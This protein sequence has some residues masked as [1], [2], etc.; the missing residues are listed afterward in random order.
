MDAIPI[1]AM[2]SSQKAAVLLLVVATGCQMPTE[3]STTSPAPTTSDTATAEDPAESQVYEMLA[4]GTHPNGTQLRVDRIEMLSDSVVVSGSVTN[5]SSYGIS[6]DRGVTR[7]AADDGEVALLIEGLPEEPI[8]PG[9]ELAVALRFGYLTNPSAV[10]LILNSGEGSSKADPTTSSPNIELG[11]IDL[12]SETSRPA[13]PDPIP[14]RR[15]IA[16]PTGVELQIEG[17]NFT[18]NRIGVWVRIANPGRTNASIA[19]SIA[20]SLLVDD[21]GNRYPLVLPERE[22]SMVIP[23]GSAR[24]GVLSFAGRIHPDAT[25]LNLGLNAGAA[26]DTGDENTIYPRLISEAIDLDGDSAV[27]PL[28]NPLMVPSVAEHPSGLR[29]E[30]VAIAFQSDSSTAELLVPNFTSDQVALAAFP[31]YLKD[32]RNNRYPLVAPTGNPQLVL[33]SGTSLEGTFAFS[34]RVADSAGQISLVLNSGGSADDPTSP[35]PAFRL[36]PFELVRPTAE[37][38]KPPCRRRAREVRGRTDHTDSHPVRS[39]RS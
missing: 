14:V 29:V 25:N 11:P 21:L 20:P 36:G 17:I 18:E 34:G 37:Q 32:D 3:T 10:T 31:T 30:L 35:S 23:T 15:S 33:D 13:L 4:L 38:T 8:P 9:S 7:L 5:G 6:L 39:H 16:S 28:P 1:G 27:V 19:P 2:P 26:G 12:N 22:G 24:S